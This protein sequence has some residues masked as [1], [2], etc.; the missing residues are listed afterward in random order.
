MMK[1]F[2]GVA[3]AFTFLVLGISALLTPNDLLGCS[4][5][6]SNV[7]SCQA[8][9]AI[10]AVSGGDTKARAQSAIDLYKNGWSGKIIFSGAAAD[11]DS[12]SNAIVMRDMAISSGIPS[13]AI[14][15]D[16]TSKT[17]RENAIN[18][19]SIM[20]D[21]NI[22]TAILTTSPYHQ[23]RAVWEFE[24]AMPDISFKSKPASDGN[25]DFWWIKP[26]GWWLAISEVIGLV[27]VIARGI[28]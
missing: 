22:K 15:I 1:I 26:T 27:I 13:G 20:E 8:V 10:V 14:L 3:A 23:R 4:S 19:K 18:V 28:L 11:P 16:E 24:Q 17:T 7:N 2:L 5:K 21:Y 12:P 6:P 9:D 25:W